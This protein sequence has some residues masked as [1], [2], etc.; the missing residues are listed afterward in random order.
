MKGGASLTRRAKSLL[1]PKAPVLAVSK[2]SSA[3]AGE[4]VPRQ[5]TPK[6]ISASSV[7]TSIFSVVGYTS[8][9]TYCTA[10]TPLLSFFQSTQPVKPNAP[11]AVARSVPPFWYCSS[12]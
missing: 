1:L 3:H 10:N 2:I 11:A 8:G 6:G 4:L 5:V 9:H 12:I 7:A